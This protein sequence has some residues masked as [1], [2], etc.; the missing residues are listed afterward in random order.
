MS[1]N[2]QTSSQTPT[3][4]Q[5]AIEEAMATLWNDP[6]PPSLMANAY[7]G[8]GKTTTL[9]NGAQRLKPKSSFALAFNKKIALE[10]EARLPKFFE[11][12]SF[13]ALGHRAWGAA[14]GTR[15]TLDDKKIGRLTSEVLKEASTGKGKK[16]LP[17]D[18]WDFTRRLVTLAMNAGLIPEDTTN[19]PGLL[20]DTFQNWER[21]ALD[22]YI[23][24]NPEIIGYATEVLRRS[25]REGRAGIICFDDQIYLSALFGGNFPRASQVLVDEYQDLSPLNIIQLSKVAGGPIIAAGDPLQSIYAF[26]GADLFA[27]DKI[28]AL[29]AQWLDLPLTLTFRCPKV[30]VARQQDH[31]IGFRAHP[32]NREGTFQQW[33]PP[34][35]H[36]QEPSAL[37]TNSDLL[38]E[39]RSWAGWTWSQLPPGE[40]AVLCRNNAPLLKLAF[41]LIR[42]GIGVV[43]LGRDI[44]KGLIALSKKIFPL[45]ALSAPACL[46]MVR[47][48]K[49]KEIELALSAGN[50]DKIAGIDDRAECLRAVLESEGV[51]NAGEARSKLD[52]LFSREA[53]QV[54]LSTIHRAKGLE[55]PTVLHLDPWRVPSKQARRAGGKL[56]DQELNLKYVCETRAQEHLILASL[57]DFEL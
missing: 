47:E 15:L 53:G 35:G 44:G 8:C 25:I 39:L 11:V 28:R 51:A 3:D 5:L 31:A 54:K 33:R 46:A 13:N 42:K 52:L 22:A 1:P 36:L 17:E 38:P 37:P 20:L 30:V 23:L 49:A 10:L 34:L 18:T 16:P 48:W 45:D 57:E 19:P 32:T 4:E 9:V 40:I 21:L 50:E 56:L 2:P 6:S 12:R 55:W 29:R 43:M 27:I 26:R 14:I 24:P 41:K 7:A